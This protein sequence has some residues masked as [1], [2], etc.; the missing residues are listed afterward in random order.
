MPRRPNPLEDHRLTAVRV[1]QAWTHL[2]H[3]ARDKGWNLKVDFEFEG[4]RAPERTEHTN[5]VRDAQKAWAPGL[6]PF[7]WQ[8][9]ARPY[10]KGEGETDE[11]TY[12]DIWPRLQDKGVRLAKIHP[13]H[14]DEASDI[15]I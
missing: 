11:E 7:D 14:R 5:K 6:T 4:Y 8:K 2:L 1:T 15:S 13:I 12:D 10:L 3:I 9:G